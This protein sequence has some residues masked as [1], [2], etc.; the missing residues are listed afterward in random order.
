MLQCAVPLGRS[1]DTFSAQ[2]PTNPQNSQ[3]GLFTDKLQSLII[4]YIIVSNL[5]LTVV[6]DVLVVANFNVIIWNESWLT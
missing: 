6:L 4:Y 5:S 2:N 1:T 3:V